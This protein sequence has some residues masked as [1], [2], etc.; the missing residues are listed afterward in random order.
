[1]F[2]EKYVQRT[3]KSKKL[4]EEA[5]KYLPGGVS[6]AIRFFEPYPFYVSKAE[7]RRVWDIDGNAYTDY[8]MGHG[9]LLMGHRYPPVIEAI[10][11]QLNLLPHVGFSHEWEVKLAKQI[12]EMVESVEL[13]RFTNSGTEAT[14]YSIRLARA[15]T[16]KR[17]IGK[18]EGGWH[19]G[20]D[21]LHIAVSPPYELPGSLGITEGALKDTVILPYND[22][23]GVREIVKGLE[24]A[25]IIVE[26][27]LGAGGFI[28]SDPEFLKGLRELCDELDALLIFDEVITGFRLSPGGA[29]KLYRV[30]PDLTV[31]GKILGG[32]EFPAGGFGGKRDV[33]ELLDQL[34]YRDPHER[35]F[36]GG[37]FAANPITTRAGYTLLRELQRRS[38]IYDH[39]NRL[40]ERA[41][42]ELQRIFDERGFNAHVTGIGS[43]FTVHFTPVKPR[44]SKTAQQRRDVSLARS[45]FKHLLD[46]G[47]VAMIQDMQHFFISAS[48]RLEDIDE[49]VRVTEEFID[50]VR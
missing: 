13:V 31:F 9:A 48:H 22:L 1:M 23:E 33:M 4:F 28:P 49:L 12:V 37:T 24:L 11:D 40:G 26:P 16:G 21:A 47:I 32:G 34:K 35:V 25:A 6:Y 38:E 30:K 42:D 19:G 43:L 10:K 8:W 46:N 36:Q 29:Q 45:Y 3:P 50:K 14:M 27:V 44:D 18:F 17:L 5:R 7:G 15:Y 2:G 39:I 20:Y 41:R